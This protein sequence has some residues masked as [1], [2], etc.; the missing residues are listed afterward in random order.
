MHL[1]SERFQKCS[2]FHIYGILVSH[3]SM[4]L[5]KQWNSSCR[6]TKYHL[7]VTDSKILS[8][9]W[10]ICK[11]YD[12]TYQK[13]MSES[14]VIPVFRHKVAENC[15]RLGSDIASSGNFLSTARCIITQECSSHVW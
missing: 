12:K 13:I 15:A 4:K 9:L 10:S 2:H 6:R 3:C 14:C 5:N 1:K 11:N 7:T 8:Y